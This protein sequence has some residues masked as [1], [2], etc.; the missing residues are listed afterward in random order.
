MLT[1][2]KKYIDLFLYLSAFFS[3]VSGV[4]YLVDKFELINLF[5][6]IPLGLI[7]VVS[8]AIGSLLYAYI[9]LLNKEDFEL[10]DETA[11][12]SVEIL[13][14]NGDAQ[15]NRTVVCKALNLIVYNRDHHMY[16]D[17]NKMTKRGTKLQAWDGEGHRLH[18]NFVLDKPTRKTFRVNFPRSIKN[19][20]QFEYSYRYYWKGLFPTPEDYFILADTALNLRF[21]LIL[22]KNI[23]FNYI[24]VIEKFQDSK[25]YEL[26]LNLLQTSVVGNNNTVREYKFKRR[27]RHS[28]IIVKWSL[29]Y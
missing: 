27:K 10:L 18:T 21:K 26:H 20:D 28:R 5:S 23:G 24:K 7:F 12:Y 17:G 1:I 4:G 11:S 16:S 15:I 6:D 3:L 22:S 2:E 13:N 19:G 9:K 25:E 29:Q 8:F 14:T